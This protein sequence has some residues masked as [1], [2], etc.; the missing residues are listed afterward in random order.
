MNN[1]VLKS[2]LKTLY[3]LTLIS[4][5]ASVTLA[6]V[7]GQMVK[8]AAAE[9][10]LIELNQKQ[11]AWLAQHPVIRVGLD[12]DFPPYEFINQYNTH[13]GI[14]SDY[15]KEMSKVLGIKFEV[16]TNL[17]WSEVL[18]RAK[19]KQIDLLPLVTASPERGNYLSFTTPYIRYQLAI[20][21]S[22][23][24]VASA[25]TLADLAGKKVA[26][27]QDYAA[28][29]QV[30]ERQPE[31][32]PYY[33][34]TVIEGLNAVL[35]GKAV[36]MVAD[37][38]T[39]SYKIREFGLT[40]LRL[41][42]FVEIPV[43]GFSMGVRDDWSELT[44]ILDKALSAIPEYRHQQI[45]E[46]WIRPVE[47]EDQT[48]QLSDSE[49][50]FIKNHPVI[51]VGV[52]PD[53][54]PYEFVDAQ[55]NH[56]GISSD[57]LTVLAKL[58]G[59]TFEVVPDLSWTQVLSDARDK[60]IDMLAAA[61]PTPERQAFLTFTD[62]YIQYQ[63]AIVTQEGENRFQT[64]KDLAG[65]QV[66]LVK[67]YAFTELVLQ[68]GPDI[69]PY[70]VDTVLDGLKAV[71][72]GNAVA[73]VADVGSMA[74]KIRE[75]SMVSLKVSGFTDIDAKGL[76][77]GVRDD[78]PEWVSIL[79]K[80]LAAISY[81]R[82]QQIVHSWIKPDQS[83]D[84]TIQLS[85]DEKA[86]IK[87]HPIIRLGIDPEFIPF[88]FVDEA[89]QYSGMVSDYIK[90]LNERLGT[91]MVIAHQS[92]WKEAVAK[93][94]AGDLDALPC[95]GLTQERQ[96]FF[97]YSDAYIQYYRV[98]ITR[99]D[100]P[101][102]VDL[103][104]LEDKRV[105]VQANSSHEGYLRDHSSIVPEIFP[106]LQ[107]TILSV[108]SGKNDV[109]VGNLASAMYWIR[110][111]NLTNLKVAG[112]LSHE[113][114]N[115][116][117]AVRKDWPELTSMINK[118]LATISKAERK[119]I[120]EKWVNVK[121]E[122]VTDYAL[123]W[124]LVLAFVLI[125][126]AV[127]IW[128]YKINQ[129]KRLAQSARDEAEEAKEKLEQAN[130]QMHAIFDSASAGIVMIKERMI[131]SCN[132]RMD[133]MYGC[134]SGEQI[135]QST[136]IWYTDD[137][138]YEKV[139]REAYEHISRN[140]THV[141]ETLAV[142]KDGSRFWARASIHAIDHHDLSKGSVAIV[143]D[144]SRERAIMQEMEASRVKIEQA[145]M[146]MHAIFDSASAGIAMI[147]NRVIISCNRRMDEMYGYE[148]GE[149]V[150]HS[151][152]MW[153]ED[154][155]IYARIDREVYE[156]LGMNETHRCERWAVR[157]DGSRFWARSGIHALDH[158]DLSK[159]VV[160]V[161][162]DISRER[163]I[164]L[165]MEQAREQAEEA[166][167]A[168]AD[169][170]ANMSH[171][172]RTPM[173][174]V[175]GMLY[176]ALRSEMPPALH[177]YLTK[178]QGAANSLLS[179]I[180][181]ILD[182]SKI[183][184]G[185]LDV[186]S[187]EFSLDSVIE[188]L[189]DAIGFQAEQKGVEFLIRYDAN[190]PITLVGDPLR[191]G[192]VL[193]NLCSNA[194]KFTEA[195]EVELSFHC[196]K[197]SKKGMTLQV[198][199]R[200][201]GIGMAAGMQELIFQ[202]FTQ[203]DDS[204][205]RQFGG[206]GLGLAISKLLVE[207]MGGRIWVEDSVP[208][209]GST[210]CFTVKLDLSRKAQVHQHAL[211][212]QAGPLLKGVRALVVDD[213]ETS[214]E[215][216]GEMLRFFHIDTQSVHT[217]AA[218]IE[219]LQQSGERPFDMVLM[220]W[221]MPGM[222]GDEVTRRIHADSNI[223]PQPKVVMVTSFG[224]EEVMSL[225]AQAGVDGFLLKPVS[226]STLLDTTLSVLG[227]GRIFTDS[228]H[229]VRE[230]LSMDSLSFSGAHL[231]LVEDNDINREFAR[232]LMQS[233]HVTVDEAVNG[234][235]A[236]AMVQQRTYDG[237][238]MDIQMPVMD[239]LEATR[240]IRA[241][242]DALGEKRFADLPI[243]AMTAMAMVKDAEKCLQAGMNDH[244]TKPVSPERLTQALSK[245]LPVT[246]KAKSATAESA[247]DAELTDYPAD[248]MAL[249]HFDAVAG[250]RRIGGKA[251]AYRKQLHRFRD[252]YPDAVDELQLLINSK[253]MQAAEDY[254]HAIK[255]VFGALGADALFDS[256]TSIDMLLKEGVMPLPEQFEGMRVLLQQAMHEIDGLTISASVQPLAAEE[257]GREELLAK[258]A[259]LKV[260][261]KRDVGAA[262]DL[263]GKIR[264]G[265]T[266]TVVEQAVSEM[267]AGMELF[268]I[269]DVLNQL[270]RLLEQI[271]EGEL[272]SS[273]GVGDG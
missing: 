173:N 68:A 206:T 270:D 159:G 257:L 205:T 200:D 75:F 182:F 248:L 116:H 170:L 104:D 255:G 88:E 61:T 222:N 15:L 58:L 217:G 203:A 225:A 138:T 167:R 192:Q 202:K 97:D 199:V 151:T 215:I 190:I 92:G 131:T 234:K 60:K 119:Q 209:E 142:R 165:E 247:V 210:F 229:D 48:I 54:A 273:K 204:T 83:E 141:G 189:T 160:M 157:K 46:N 5:A 179:I 212:E 252:R 213:N 51:R 38:G 99:S 44:G 153:Y 31:I 176:L 108:S 25:Q 147:N 63:V 47:V 264:A 230:N 70:Y 262:E 24:T 164:M 169:F 250:I 263:L 220:D 244:I 96:K 113:P 249:M 109:I 103:S 196:L 134:E 272:V 148:A 50:A 145:N 197:R 228:R 8:D 77:M 188:Q 132:R 39:M 175:L 82:H 181:D 27:V 71:V 69:Q 238:L 14:S 3:M 85:N 243:I 121:Y 118:G 135:G 101:F 19:D 146:Q 267:S 195:G 246:D 155:E 41:S 261:L 241:L 98:A 214:C 266:G 172:L 232:E 253:G 111:M 123:V 56:V 6:E 223:Q 211:A 37:A 198:T 10:N 194:I 49:K 33:V 187:I 127:L 29:K 152:R 28:S 93:A 73:M 193:L 72:Q 259:A 13:S 86:F 126:L 129:Q 30:L 64:L 9:S 21:S 66:A 137:E 183:E 90:L 102:V 43:Q 227:R 4:I 35:D 184:A 180:N 125:I 235:E 11:R 219:M 174:A 26:L 105:A 156:K 52:D 89:G 271:G 114:G 136:R 216:L 158:D 171:E 62:P 1:G 12:A 260:L 149:Q 130:M 128:N 133:E 91:N 100:A 268:E 87:N 251:Q 16:A 34:A 237:V 231:L 2:A 186:E 144:I 115:L 59:V 226:P 124:K 140:E 178:A 154:D 40:P 112:A 80:A 53:F 36:A 163:E 110:K 107:E 81:P 191:L 256:A 162:E 95:I 76:A 269:D 166:T 208:G 23:T 245:W 45:L 233:M 78:W 94:K 185:K 57:Y 122:A 65:K 22:P 221:R 265:V 7:S 240:K 242:A 106:T 17:S 224:R 236:L 84:K 207:L 150:G 258:L 177:N 254:C 201:T 74:Y 117:F 55:N 143:E 79:Q 120:S 42:G 239:G 168:K 139:G 218:A 161:V 18:N 20:V 67:G 32:Q